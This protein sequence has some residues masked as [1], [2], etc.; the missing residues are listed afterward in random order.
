VQPQRVVVAPRRDPLA[1]WRSEAL[2]Q[3]VPYPPRR[4]EPAPA[5]ELGARRPDLNELALIEILAEFI[6]DGV[7][8]REVVRR[9]QIDARSVAP[10]RFSG[11]SSCSS[12]RGYAGAIVGD[13]VT[14]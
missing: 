6:I 10:E 5:I 14:S 8:D 12:S 11:G 4:H 3:I 2:G 13:I 9:V 1:F 7:V